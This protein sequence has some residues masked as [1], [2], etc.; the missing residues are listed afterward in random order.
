[1]FAKDFLALF[2]RS[3]FISKGIKE[4]LDIKV[5]KKSLIR[6]ENTELGACA[7]KIQE[8]EGV[9]VSIVTIAV[10]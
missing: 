5:N 4:I 3:D 8:I 9:K 1:M 2:Y 6:I 10:A 7:Q